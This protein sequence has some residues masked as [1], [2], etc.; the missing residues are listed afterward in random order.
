MASSIDEYWA[1][2]PLRKRDFPKE[3]MGQ[4]MMNTLYE[5]NTDLWYKVCGVGEGVFDPYQVDP[6]YDDSKIEDFSEFIARHW[7]NP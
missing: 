7:N 4:A 6:F 3:R 1:N 2:V 5:H